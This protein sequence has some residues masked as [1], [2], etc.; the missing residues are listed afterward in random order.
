LVV[1]GFTLNFG[2]SKLNDM[3]PKSNYVEVEPG[4]FI[5]ADRTD[6]YQ[7]MMEELEN[8]P[9]HEHENYYDNDQDFEIGE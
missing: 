4:I 3:T 7:Q 1:S 6:D 5:P 2:V 9:E 8:L